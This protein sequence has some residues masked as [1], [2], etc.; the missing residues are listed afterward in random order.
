M[1]IVNKLIEYGVI[2]EFNDWA[3]HFLAGTKGQPKTDPIIIDYVKSL[4]D[5]VYPNQ[6]DKVKNCKLAPW[7]VAI[8]RNL[9]P[10]NIGT[11]ERNKMIDVANWFKSTGTEGP[12][13]NKDLNGA[14]EF[15]VAKNAESERKKSENPESEGGGA[16]QL[17]AE[18]DGRI[19]RI[20]NVGDGSGR[21]WVEVVDGSWLAEPGEL[22]PH[23][24]WG[25]KCQSEG[26]HGF[27]SPGMLNVQLI[28]PPKGNPNGKWSTQLAIA[29]PRGTGNVKET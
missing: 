25:V 27:Q 20:G 28:G 21:I 12:F 19:R 22:N 7:L 10:E 23:H 15:V 24:T 8:V 26:Q 5:D 16:Y 14:Y 4:L 2:Q 18:K 13:K 17:Q 29:G 1:K 3:Q 11:A 9:G 6:P